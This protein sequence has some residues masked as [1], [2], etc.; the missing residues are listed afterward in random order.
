MEAIPYLK[1]S[2]GMKD[3]KAQAGQSNHSTLKNHVRDLR[4]CKRAVETA[5]ELNNTEDGAN[6]DSECCYGQGC[7]C[8][9]D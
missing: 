6:E 1:G 2:P 4:V 9:L 7:K 8:V 3:R 5:A